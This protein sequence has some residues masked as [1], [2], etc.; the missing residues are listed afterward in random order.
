MGR[1]GTWREGEQD[2][3]GTHTCSHRSKLQGALTG[4]LVQEASPDLALGWAPGAFTPPSLLTLPG[5]L[6]LPSS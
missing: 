5:L 2:D 1:A 3:E 6:E 4:C